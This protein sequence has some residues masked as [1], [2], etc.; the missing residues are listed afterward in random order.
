MIWKLCAW[1]LNCH[2]IGQYNFDIKVPTPISTPTGPIPRT[3]ET[4]PRLV[5]S[6]S[7]SRVARTSLLIIV[8]SRQQQ[9]LEKHGS[10]I[11]NWRQINKKRLLGRPGISFCKI[12]RLRKRIDKQFKSHHLYMEYVPYACTKQHSHVKTQCNRRKD[13]NVKRLGGE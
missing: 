12:D 10:C 4:L 7:G 1:I 11:E 13:S 2:H 3:I 5:T 6:S 8:Y 9:M